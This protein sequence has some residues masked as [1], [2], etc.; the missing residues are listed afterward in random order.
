MD[1]NERNRLS[2]LAAVC[3]A[4]L[5]IIVCVSAMICT[6]DMFSQGKCYAL[7]SG[8]LRFDFLR[9]LLG[10]KGVLRVEFLGGRQLCT[11]FA[12]LL[13]VGLYLLIFGGEEVFDELLLAHIGIVRREGI[14]VQDN[15]GGI[16]TGLDSICQK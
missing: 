1:R 6:D 11:Q 7:H 12:Y 9:Q 4:D 10:R 13:L 14:F 15:S 5:F 3:A 2:L 16:E 8:I